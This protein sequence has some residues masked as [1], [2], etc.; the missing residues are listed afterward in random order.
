MGRR[1]KKA[2]DE[3]AG[4]SKICS[5]CDKELP[6]ESFYMMS[7]R[8]YRSTIC[9]SCKN[10]Y[11]RWYSKSHRAESLLRQKDYR[12]KNLQRVRG[13]EKKYRI[14]HPISERTKERQKKWQRDNY[15]RMYRNNINARIAQN[16]RSRMRQKVLGDK[17]L[18]STI[19]LLGCSVQYFRLYLENQFA[20]G[21]SWSNYGRI[22]HI[23]HFLPCAGFDLSI[24]REKR[25]CFHYL[26][27]RP[28]FSKDNM[29]KGAKMPDGT[30][31]RGKQ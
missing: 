6:I 11:S 30:T 2:R 4:T 31:A 7:G 5:K 12:K 9:K 24:E 16:I 27:L 21:M 26:N 13:Y 19:D 15:D 18:S 14:S 8:N 17:S 29:S 22:W 20:G 28:E 23:D 3:G 10:G 25:E 1:K